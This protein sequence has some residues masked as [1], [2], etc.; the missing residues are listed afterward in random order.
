MFRQKNLLRNPLFNITMTVVIVLLLAFF[1]KFALSG[2]SSSIK[3]DLE[4][5]D[6]SA[7]ANMPAAP[8]TAD[9][10]LEKL[11]SVDSSRVIDTMFL[12][13]CGEKFG[14]DIYG[15]ICDYLEEN[16]YTD[17]MW[18][19]VCGF[20][21]YALFDLANGNAEDYN[22]QVIESGSTAKIVFAGDVSLDDN[23]NW[24][25]LVVHRNNLG[26]LV[27]AAFSAELAEQML[28]ADIFC[29]NLE[30]PLTNGKT[31]LP[32]RAYAH[33]SPTEN[34][35]ILGLLGVDMVNLANDRI[36]DYSAAGLT[37]TIKALDDKDIAYIGAGSSLEDAKTPRYVIA[38]GRKIAVVAA[39][40]NATNL[41]APEA[42]STSA[43]LLY[44]TNSAYFTE[45]IKEA[46]ENSDYVIVYTDWGLGDNTSADETQIGLAHDFIDF[47]AD[48]VIGCRSTVMQNIEYYS[49]K[50]IFYGLGNFW[51]ETDTHEA[52]LLKL[53]FSSFEKIPE[54][55]ESDSGE[56]A[57]NF[58]RYS[59]SDEPLIYCLPCIQS[60]AVTRLV[61]GTDEGTA[62]Y[63][64]L[65]QTS[66]GIV[67]SEDG[68]V[69]R[70]E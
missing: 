30:S 40:R 55:A 27:N 53:E 52:L 41:T 57:P 14:N 4:T 64:K 34:A 48:I 19:K 63:G 29:V 8:K 2:Y 33:S 6:T 54:S 43:G 42:A 51:Y 50:P 36:Y 13:Y 7:L 59:F 18:E 60:N 67:F 3:K 25:P 9:D 58:V 20:S 62:I 46:R 47:G 39:L 56:N 1:Y 26:N 31:K 5:L 65:L 10:V 32:A 44:S 23:W 28:G 35:N 12:E 68:V 22:Y 17:E 69:S 38:G 11:E 49:G 61:L 24:S 15:N 21:L 16:E 70:A 45:A 66:P 37:D